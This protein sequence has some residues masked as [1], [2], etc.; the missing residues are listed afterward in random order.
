[1][2]YSEYREITE[3]Y[4][5]TEGLSYDLALLWLH[6]ERLPVEL[7]S[8]NGCTERVIRIPQS[9]RNKYGR[10]VA[11]VRISPCAFRS[12]TNVTDVMIPPGVTKIERET[13]SGCT[14]LKRIALPK[15]VRSIGVA[16]FADCASLEDI[17]YE[18]TADEWGAIRIKS[19]K[20]VR[21]FGELIGGTP[22]QEIIDDR[23]VRIR[24]NEALYTATIH[25]CCETRK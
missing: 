19:E 1:M 25:F 22:V 14:S 21:V 4:P 15:S 18:G 20:R 2:N 8:L 5:N 12:N 24:G 13:F 23:L 11:V 3:H 9:V 7:V 6:P 16:A 17:Y 10:E